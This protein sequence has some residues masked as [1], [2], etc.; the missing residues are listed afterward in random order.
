MDISSAVGTLPAWLAAGPLLNAVL[1]V[2]SKRNGGVRESE[3]YLFAYILPVLAG[4]LSSLLY[5]LAVHR[6]WPLAVYYVVSAMNQFSFFAIAI[7]NTFWVTEA[8]PRWAA[9][10]LVAVGGVSYAVAFGLQLAL[11][12]WL[13]QGFLHVGIGL[14]T[15]QLLSGLIFVPIAFWGKGVRQI[16]HGRWAERREGALRP[17]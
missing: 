8:F 1:K 2:M 14:M 4:A 6:H 12:R 13:K 16:I 11:V 9:P 5:G 10:A 15:A 3:H 7:A 17:L